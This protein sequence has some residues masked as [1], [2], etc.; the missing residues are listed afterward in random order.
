M[1]DWLSR[2]SVGSFARCP[3]PA[4]NV[5]PIESWLVLFP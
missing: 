3:G 5:A 2:A 4:S 1:S